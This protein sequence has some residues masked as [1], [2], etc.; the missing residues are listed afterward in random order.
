ML[1]NETQRKTQCNVENLSNGSV[2]LGV[3]YKRRPNWHNICCT[4]QHNAITYLSFGRF[5]FLSPELVCHGEGETRK[6]EIG[7]PSY[8][9]TFTSSR[10]TISS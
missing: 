9:S 3:W 8:D 5:Y 4:S 10:R 1:R 7:M 6:K 2:A